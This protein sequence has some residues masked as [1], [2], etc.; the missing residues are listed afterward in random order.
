[1]LPPAVVV[2]GAND[3]ARILAPGRRLTLLS[4][5]G[6]ALFAGCGWWIALAGRARAL[7]PELIAADVLDCADSPARALGALRLG[8]RMLILDPDAPSRTAVCE[9]ASSLGAVVLEHRPPALDMA[10][11]GA[12][13]RLGACL[14]VTSRCA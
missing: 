1:M 5:R 12:D 4:A 7:A 6:A 10:E 14:D 8:Q 11:R 2:H 9:A 13:R 3:L